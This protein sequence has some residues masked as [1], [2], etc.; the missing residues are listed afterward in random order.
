MNAI[1][2]PGEHG[3]RSDGRL[4]WAHG[5][6][7]TAGGGGPIKRLPTHAHRQRERAR[8]CRKFVLAEAAAGKSRTALIWG[9]NAGD[10]GDEGSPVRVVIKSFSALTTP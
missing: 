5:I 3:L 8:E 9:N 2:E 10:V 7:A 1:T 6:A 4:G